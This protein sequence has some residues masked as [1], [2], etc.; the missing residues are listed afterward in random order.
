MKI[1]VRKFI[2]IMLPILLIGCGYVPMYKNLKNLDFKITVIDFSG[3]RKVN[4]IIKSRLNSYTE[5]EKSKNYNIVI[6]SN[7]K[8]IIIAKD[9]TGAATEYKLT[10]DAIF[11]VSSEK[12]EKQLKYTE[13]FNLQSMSDKLEEQDYEKSI[14][15]SLVNTITRKLILQLSQIQ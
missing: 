6:N 2:L 9:T 1:L 14:K 7:Y 3:D 13:S 12:F 11:T 8:K 10:V 15:N 4:N 5:N